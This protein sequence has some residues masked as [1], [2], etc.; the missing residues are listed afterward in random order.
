MT[1]FTTVAPGSLQ[2]GDVG[3]RA[4]A[5]RRASG[6]ATVHR[7]RE[8]CAP[9]GQVLVMPDGNG[10][11]RLCALTVF[12]TMGTERAVRWVQLDEEHQPTDYQSDNLFRMLSME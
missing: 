2:G 5:W 8:T 12:E 1:R 4:R 10:T 7:Q 9:D 6:G 11:G 3:P